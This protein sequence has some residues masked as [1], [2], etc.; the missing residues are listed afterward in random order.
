MKDYQHQPLRKPFGWTGQEA[1]LVIQIERLFDDIYR[2]VGML[3]EK[4]NSIDAECIKSIKM[5]GTAV[6]VANNEAN[7]G[8][9]AT[10]SQNS[11]TNVVSIS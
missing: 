5:N 7:I 3:R 8:S 1:S 10:I 2:S 4:V 11:T 9:V 6:P